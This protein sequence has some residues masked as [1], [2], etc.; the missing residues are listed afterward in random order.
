MINVG[1]KKEGREERE[2]YSK[3]FNYART[4]EKINL[5]RRKIRSIKI[6]GQGQKTVR[7]YIFRRNL[8]N[9]YFQYREVK[10]IR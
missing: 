3:L 9:N 1:G 2:V 6:P 5:N 8:F 4:N 7:T 10:E